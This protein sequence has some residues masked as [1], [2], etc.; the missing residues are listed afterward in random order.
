MTIDDRNVV[1]VA[2]LLT[3]RFECV[4]GT[5]TAHQVAK[6]SRVITQCPSCG[7]DWL[8]HEGEQHKAIQR[9]MMGLKGA[10]AVTKDAN[11][12]LRFEMPRKA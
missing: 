1:D 5:T 2:D 6:W 9:L 10:A 12:K 3:V 11:F 7:T 4:C 8:D